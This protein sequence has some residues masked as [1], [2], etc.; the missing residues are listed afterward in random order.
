MTDQVHALFPDTDF[1]LVRMRRDRHAKLHAEMERHGVDVLVLAGTGNV[2]YA[3]GARWRASELSQAVQEPT[4]AVLTRDGSPHLFTAYPE[5]APSELPADRIHEPLLLEYGEGVEQLAGIIRDL[6]GAG[7]LSVAIDEMSAAAHATLPRLLDP[8]RIVGA[9]DVMGAA[10]LCKTD[11][12]IECIRRSQRINEIAMYDVYSILAPGVRQS[13]LTALFLRRIFE[14]GATANAVDPIWQATPTAIAHGPWTTNGDVAFPTS[15][16][17]RILRDG[18]LILNDSG[19]VYEGYASDFG[20]TWWAGAH[21]PTTRQRDHLKRWK[22]VVERVLAVTKPGATGLELNRAG[23]EGETARRPWLDHFYLIHGIGTES[24]EMPF[25]GT[26]LGEAF[27]ESIVL[28]PGMVMVLEPVI[29]EDG[30]GGYRAE[31]IVA[32]TDDGYRMLSNFPY[33]PFE[34]GGA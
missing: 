19:I 12:E 16:T 4:V 5:G 31:D 34:D 30:Y 7:E 22:A 10:K 1:D 13:D 27:D 24:A 21:R 3:T 2:H 23:R 18:E 8:V 20:R 15:T 33:M 25:I 9:S 14:L 17:D 32:V 11:D 26:D 29:W 28:A 6:V